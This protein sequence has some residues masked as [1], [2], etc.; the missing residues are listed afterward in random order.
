MRLIEKIIEMIDESIIIMIDNK[1]KSHI[2]RP[3]E[4]ILKLIYTLEHDSQFIDDNFT[5]E[6]IHDCIGKAKQGLPNVKTKTNINTNALLQSLLYIVL[7]VTT[8]EQIELLYDI[9]DR[10]AF[11]GTNEIK[12]II[13]IIRLISKYINS[14]SSE[15]NLI[16]QE[17]I[18]SFNALHFTQMPNNSNIFVND[19]VDN[20]LNIL[21]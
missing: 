21:R 3:Y 16:M 4:L 18:N 7:L 8:D 17:L 19:I 2:F 5:K 20:L 12:D 14:N 13:H 11:I 10:I 1:I 15:N 6:I 9:L